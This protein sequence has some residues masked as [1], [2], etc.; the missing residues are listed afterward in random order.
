MDKI[1]TDIEK[2]FA[3]I[4]KNIQTAAVLGYSANLFAAR[5]ISA[6]TDAERNEAIKE[7][8]EILKEFGRVHEQ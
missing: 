5:I 7:A 8:N 6:K 2:G 1:K 4:A 3:L